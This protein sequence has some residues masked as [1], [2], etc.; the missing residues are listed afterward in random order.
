MLNTSLNAENYNFV[1][2]S[3]FNN[4]AN[5]ILSQRIAKMDQIIPQIH[6]NDIF[7]V[8]IV[9]MPTGALIFY[10]RF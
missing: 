10:A 5:W 3:I 4:G 2:T 1:D 8:K 9:K 7:V 6:L